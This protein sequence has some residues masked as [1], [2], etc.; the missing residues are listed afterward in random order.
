MNTKLKLCIIITNVD[1]ALPFEWAAVALKDKYD[2]S[3]ILLN[4]AEGQF[5]IFLKS[6]NINFKRVFYSGKRDTATAFLK[7]LAY[8]IKS[9][10][11]IVHA[12]FIE[13]QI[14]GLSAARLAGEN[15]DGD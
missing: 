12:N 6:Q 15:I 1:K 4:A 8:F 7:V 9:K 2:L 14:I 11:D 10:P 5:E 3:Y 13:S